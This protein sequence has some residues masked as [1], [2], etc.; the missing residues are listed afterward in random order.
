LFQNFSRLCANS[1]LLHLQN[2]ANTNLNPPNSLSAIY[3]HPYLVNRHV[4][5]VAEE[6]FSGTSLQEVDIGIQG[7]F[8]CNLSMQASLLYT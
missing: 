8:F 6:E 2:W 5:T 4:K 3:H 7:H 1:Q